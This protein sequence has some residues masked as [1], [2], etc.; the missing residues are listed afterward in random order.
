MKKRKYFK[1][2]SREDNPNVIIRKENHHTGYVFETLHKTGKFYR[3]H[4]SINDHEA[5][6][7]IQHRVEKFAPAD[8]NGVI[9]CANILKQ[10]DAE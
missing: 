8:G 6:C 3:V 4:P 5:L 7:M 10:L 1:I 9:I 2:R